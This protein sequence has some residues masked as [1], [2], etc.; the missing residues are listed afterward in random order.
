MRHPLLKF[1]WTA[2]LF[3]TLVKP[4][5]HALALA[6]LLTGLVLRAAEFTVPG[7]SEPPRV[8]GILKP[9]N[10]ITHWPSAVPAESSI[11]GW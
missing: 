2:T 6:G 4:S 10:G 3:S 7:F 11:P 8:D 1:R 9:G 5:L